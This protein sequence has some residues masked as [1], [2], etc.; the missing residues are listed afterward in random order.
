MDSKHPIRYS[1]E[2]IHLLRL[3][4]ETMFLKTLKRGKKQEVLAS[5][6]FE[7]SKAAIDEIKEYKREKIEKKLSF[8]LLPL[9]ILASLAAIGSFIISILGR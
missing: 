9:F 6:K 3:V 8:Y 5:R 7:P 4:L 1:S 2:P